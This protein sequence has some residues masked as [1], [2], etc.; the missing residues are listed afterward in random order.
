MQVGFRFSPVGLR[1]PK[2]DLIW[3]IAATSHTEVG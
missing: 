1:Q 2:P 3:T